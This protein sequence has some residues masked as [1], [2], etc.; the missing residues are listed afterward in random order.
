MSK[1]GKITKAVLTEEQFDWMFSKIDDLYMND[2]IGKDYFC[3]F[4]DAISWL[5]G[6]VYKQPKLK[7]YI[8]EEIDI[9]N[10]AECKLNLV[11]IIKNPIEELD[12][13]FDIFYKG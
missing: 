3:G 6:D 7:K 5:A 8:K 11:N 10:Q 13:I 4:C 9:V 2:V 12:N 1:E